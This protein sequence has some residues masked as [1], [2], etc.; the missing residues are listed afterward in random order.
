MQLHFLI[1]LKNKS[2]PTFQNNL[3][4]KMSVVSVLR[5]EGNYLVK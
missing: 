3:N 4:Y 2:A 5:G 1:T